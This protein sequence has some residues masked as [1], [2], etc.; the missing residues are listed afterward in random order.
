MMTYRKFLQ[1]IF[2]LA[3]LFKKEPIFIKNINNCL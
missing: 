1:W 2:K 3:S